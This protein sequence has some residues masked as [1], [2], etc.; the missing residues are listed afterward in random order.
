MTSGLSARVVGATVLALAWTLALAFLVKGHAETGDG[1]SAGLTA[2]AGVLIHRMVTGEARA[3]WPV[4]HRLTLARVGLLVVLVPVVVPVLSGSPPLSH[5][6]APGT[7]APG[8]GVL[9]IQSGLLVDLGVFALVLGFVL[10]AV[11]LIAATATA[12]RESAS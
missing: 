12:A 1:F 6:P 4:R 10:T 7:P 8:L 3:S 2:A 5:Y 11:E 9:E